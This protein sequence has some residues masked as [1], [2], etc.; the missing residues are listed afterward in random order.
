MAGHG[1]GCMENINGAIYKEIK[2]MKL[3]KITLVCLG[4]VVFVTVI[5]GASRTYFGL[6]HTIRLNDLRVVYLKDSIRSLEA[7]FQRYEQSKNNDTS[8]MEREKYFF[9]TGTSQY[10]MEIKHILEHFGN[11]SIP[12]KLTGVRAY[13]YDGINGIVYIVVSYIEEELSVEKL[14]VRFSDRAV[15]LKDMDYYLAAQQHKKYSFSLAEIVSEFYFKRDMYFFLYTECW[16][17]RIEAFLF[18][19]MRPHDWQ[20]YFVARIS[21]AEMEEILQSRVTASL[22]LS[23]GTLSNS[24]LLKLLPIRISVPK[25]VDFKDDPGQVQKP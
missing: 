15:L 2:N 23:D 9:E 7:S 10:R 3:S 1:N 24:E 12:P 16:E 6:R 19:H 14:H 20:D 18:P 11:T 13:Q 4:V 17:N 22:V 5:A 8:N 25:Y 21:E